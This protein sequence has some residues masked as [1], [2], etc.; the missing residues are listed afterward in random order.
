MFYRWVDRIGGPGNNPTIELFFRRGHFVSLYANDVKTNGV[1]V[2]T[3]AAWVDSLQARGRYTFLCAEAIQGSGLSPE[4]VKKALQRLARRQRVAKV[5]NYFYVIVPLEYRDA[6]GP[7]PSWF[8]DDLMK[9]MER[10][11]YVGLLSAPAFTVRLTISRRSFKFSPIA[12][13][14]R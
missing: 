13:S 11:Y 12:R 10:L 2:M 3:V 9:V 8:I 14:G 6:G 1:L 7:P 4:A 5:K